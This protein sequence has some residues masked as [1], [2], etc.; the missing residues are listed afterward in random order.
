MFIRFAVRKRD[1]DSGVEAGAL[2]AAYALLDDPD[3]AVGDREA[4][5][6]GLHWLEK[7]LETP[8]RF[9]RTRSKGYDRRKTGGIAWFKD[10]ASEHLAQMYALKFLLERYG[11]FVE[12]LQES[13]IGYV[14]WEDAHQVIA[15]PF[16]D[17]RTG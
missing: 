12:V 9:N 10:S 13:H 16:K 7:H 14:V 6:D 8:E 11:H 5:R 2:Q 4:L 15:E 17:T 1:R 3:V